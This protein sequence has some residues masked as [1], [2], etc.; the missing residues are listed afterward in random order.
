MV[1]ASVMISLILCDE[2]LWTSLVN[3]RQAKSQC[4]PSSLLI[5]SLEKV[6]P[7]IRPLFLSQKMAAN[8]P[9]KK[10]PSTAANAMMRS[11]KL[12]VFESIHFSAQ[13]AF[14]LTHGIVSMALKR[15]SLSALSL[16]YV[17]MSRLYISEWMF[18]MAIWNP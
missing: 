8:E 18:S 13:S 3:R 10:I 11:P 15:Y 2:G 4:R 12:A 5:S 14:L 17:S 16:M 9:E 7:G 1:T 6:N